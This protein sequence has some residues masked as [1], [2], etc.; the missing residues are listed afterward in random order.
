MAGGKIKLVAFDMEGV[1][2]ADPTVWEIMHRKLGTWEAQG[3]VYWERYQRGE[4]GYD[5]FARMDVAVWRGA[6]SGLLHEAARE[7]RWTGGCGEVLGAL[8][9]AGV[10]VAV[11]SNGLLCVASRLQEEFGIGPVLANRVHRDGGHLTGEI[12]ILVPY[13]SKGRMLRELAERS[14]IGP[15]EIAAVGDSASDVAMFRE[16]ALSIAF[17]QSEPSV[18]GAAG[19]RIEGGDLRPVLDLLL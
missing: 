11:I 1:L 9:E 14:G 2:S 19:H 12:D 7:V 18:A 13:D 16:A 8:R 15:G 17:G 3:R 10:T 5:E 4:F 6:P